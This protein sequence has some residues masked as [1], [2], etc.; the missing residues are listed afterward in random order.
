MKDRWEALL[1]VLRKIISLYQ[2]ILTLSQEKQQILV[3][4]KSQELEKVTK[5]EEILVLEIS[6]LEDLRRKLVGELMA[7]HSIEGEVSLS[8]L[9][10]VATPSIAAQLETFGENLRDIMKAITPINK[11]NTELIN[12]ALGFIN[13]NIN[14]LSQTVVGP[15]YAP[16]GQANEQTTRT[17]FDAKV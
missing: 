13:Y 11:L 4:A 2:T 7:T 1:A 8:Q 17:V 14:I 10:K 16:K 6:K 15:T 12:Q 5:Q 3:S 9:K